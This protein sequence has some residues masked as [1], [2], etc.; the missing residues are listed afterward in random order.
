[1]VRTESGSPSII[2][3]PEEW[4]QLKNRIEVAVCPL[5]LSFYGVP[6]FVSPYAEPVPKPVYLFFSLHWSRPQPGWL[7]R[8]ITSL[9]FPE[10]RCQ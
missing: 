10:P 8:A 5:Y 1:M 4:E 2:V 3:S 6:V 7:M 9:L